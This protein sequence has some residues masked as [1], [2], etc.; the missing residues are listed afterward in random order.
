VL[1]KFF[2]KRNTVV[3]VVMM[4]MMM[5]ICFTVANRKF[6]STVFQ[7]YDLL[8]ISPTLQPMI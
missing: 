7:F 3:V 1:E 2:R 8:L 4:M 6:D 5:M